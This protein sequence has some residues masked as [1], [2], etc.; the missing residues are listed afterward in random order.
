M[1]FPVTSKTIMGRKII[2]SGGGYF[3]LVPYPLLKR[4]STKGENGYRNHMVPLLGR[5]KEGQVMMGNDGLPVTRDVG[6]LLSYIHPRDL[7]GGQPMLEGL[8]M[9]RRLTSS[10]SSLQGIVQ[11]SLAS[12]LAA[13][14]GLRVTWD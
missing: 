1:E 4:W 8:P 6:Y 7:D 9:A 14:V 2:F 12:A 10:S 3:R 13:F 11:A 5:D